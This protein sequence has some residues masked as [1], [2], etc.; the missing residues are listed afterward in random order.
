[1]RTKQIAFGGR[2]GGVVL[3]NI[4]PTSINL[5]KRP[6]RGNVPNKEDCGK[7]I[8]KQRHQGDDLM[9]PK[10][11]ASRLGIL[12]FYSRITH[13]ILPFDH[14]RAQPPIGALNS[15]SN[16]GHLVTVGKQESF[17]L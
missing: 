15:S 17:K 10:V 2:D 1:M 12:G 4:N 13:R 16:R 9:G 11:M 3:V 7:Y 8:S 5:D 14:F 6:K